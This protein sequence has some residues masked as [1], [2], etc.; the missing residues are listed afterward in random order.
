MNRMIDA[1]LHALN[2]CT[3]GKRAKV[4]ILMSREFRLA[5]EVAKAGHRLVLVGDKFRPLYRFATENQ[6]Y[7]PALTI[8][9]RYHELP[10]DTEAFDVLIVARPMPRGS[11]IGAELARLKTH[12]KSQGTIMWYHPVYKGLLG[13]IRRAFAHKWYRL[14][15]HV[16]CK[17]A[18]ENGF[19]QIGQTLVRGRRSSRLV[20]TKAVVP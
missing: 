8:E 12:I 3:K 18:M 11:D 1:T 19:Q 17:T 2:A 15:R 5:K 4:C 14:E 7:N 6:P 9:A 20:L 13:R 16:L 10:L